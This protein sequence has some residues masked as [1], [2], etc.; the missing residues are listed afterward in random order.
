LVAVEGGILPPGLALLATVISELP[1]PVK[2][3]GPF[4]PGWEARLYGRQ[5]A[6]RYSV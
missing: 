5:D 3:A 2:I 1:Q 6:R 4:P